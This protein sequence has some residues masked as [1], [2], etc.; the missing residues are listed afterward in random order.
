[1]SFWDTCT[2]N[3]DGTQTCR[4]RLR[5]YPNFRIPWLAEIWNN[6]LYSDSEE[7]FTPP[8]QGAKTAEGEVLQ[9]STGVGSPQQTGRPGFYSFF[10]PK[11]IYSKFAEDKNAE[12]ERLAT[13]CPNFLEPTAENQEACAKLAT[14]VLTC[15]NISFSNPIELALKLSAMGGQQAIADKLLSCAAAQ[16]NKSLSGQAA[17][18]A[19]QGAKTEQT[20]QDQI[21]QVLQAATDIGSE[22]TAKERFIGAVDCGKHYAR[23]LALK[24]KALQEYLGI[25][26][27]CPLEAVAVAEEIP[28]GGSPGDGTNV[29]PNQ[30]DCGGKYTPWMDNPLGNFGDPN[31]NFSPEALAQ[32]LQSLDPVNWEKYYDI[33]FIEGGYA[34]KPLSY[35]PSSTS[36][37]AWGLYQMGHEAY[38]NL[39]IPRQMNTQYD[40]GDVEWHLQASNAVNYNNELSDSLKWCYWAA[41]GSAYLRLCSQF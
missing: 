35:N 11:A 32:H 19:V 14:A 13:E 31:C 33:A 24:P 18:G 26:A 9:S 28:P 30:D 1:M 21:G 5:I 29:P 27:Q 12:L 6:A 16:V 40:R 10:I 4:T 36:G 20:G 15:L 17:G 2:D 38:P 23:D 3:G 41:A 22:S 37:S 8:V 25:G 7:F 34:F 39:G